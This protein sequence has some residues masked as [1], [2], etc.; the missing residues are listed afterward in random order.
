MAAQKN[1]LRAKPVEPAEPK[2]RKPRFVWLKKLFGVKIS[3]GAKTVMGAPKD[4]ISGDILEKQES[5]K[6]VYL[7]IWLL[8]LGFVYITNN[9]QAE[10]KIRMINAKQKE[11][12]E[13]RYQYISNKSKLMNMSKQSEVE[14][15]LEKRGFKENVEPLKVIRI[16]TKEL[17][18]LSNE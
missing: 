3:K 1:I 15:R 10:E 2:E 17:K 8:V 13:L 18:Q 11:L 4:I 16:T 9:Y 7:L 6:M 14:K 12:K 5:Y